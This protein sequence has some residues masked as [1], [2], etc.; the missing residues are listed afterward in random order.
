MEMEK[1]ILAKIARKEQQGRKQAE[2]Q[3]VRQRLITAMTLAKYRDNIPESEAI[4]NFAKANELA[5]AD[6]QAMAEGVSV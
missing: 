4:R 3:V 5:L 6:V 2:A 1:K